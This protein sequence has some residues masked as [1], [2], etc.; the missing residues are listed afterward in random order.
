MGYVVDFIIVVIAVCVIINAWKKGFIQSVAGLVTGVVSFI[1]AYAFTPVLGDFIYKSFALDTL[2]AGIEKTIGS[3]SRTDAGKFD[4][5]SMF[6]EM[7]DALKQII[8]RYS[9][10]SDKLGEMC[11]GVTEG[12][13]KTVEKLSEYI[14]APIADTLSSAAAFIAIFVCSLIVLKL[15]VFVIDLIFKLPVLNSTNKT[16]GLLFGVCEALILAV[17][18]SSVSAAVITAL[19]SVDPVTFGAQIVEDS[20]IMKTLSSLD[21]FGLL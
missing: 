9:V 16:L 14:A 19:G 7:P 18:I 8:E 12:T 5:S 13:E 17:L 21:L 6:S 15:V 20:Y 1:A 3:L 11:A 2:S 4:L 10:D